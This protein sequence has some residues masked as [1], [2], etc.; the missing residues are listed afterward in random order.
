MQGNLNYICVMLKEIKAYFELNRR[1]DGT[2]ALLPW[3]F[4]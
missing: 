1:H 4:S 3:I 2:I